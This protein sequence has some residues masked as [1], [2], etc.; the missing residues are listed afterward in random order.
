V[1]GPSVKPQTSGAV[2]RNSTIETRGFAIFSYFTR[3][4]PS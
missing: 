2:F 1:S 4:V 3:Y